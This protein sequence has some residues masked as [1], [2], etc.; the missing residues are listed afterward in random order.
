[1]SAFGPRRKLV[2]PRIQN[3]AMQRFET[4]AAVDEVSG[5]MVE[6][7]TVGGRIGG[8]EVIVWLNDSR[9][10]I[11]VPDPVHRGPR[12]IRIFRRRHPTGKR[13]AAILLRR[14]PRSFSPQ[15]FGLDRLLC[16]GML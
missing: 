1:M 14:N 12:E 10:K 7:F 4:K 15:E 5:Q 11:F 6:Q 2:C 9:L 16:D 8:T 13:N 3:Q